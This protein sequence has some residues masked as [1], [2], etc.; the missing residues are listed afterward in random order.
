MLKNLKYVVAI[1]LMVFGYTNAE[2]GLFSSCNA[3]KGKKG[4]AAAHECVEKADPKGDPN[5]FAAFTSFHC[6]K[7]KISPGDK[8]FC[9]V[10]RNKLNNAAEIIHENESASNKRRADSE[11]R[12]IQKDRDNARER[13]RRAQAGE[14]DGFLSK[15]KRKLPW[16]RPVDRV[17]SRSGSKFP[18][19]SERSSRPEPV[20]EEE[21]GEG[22]D[23]EDA[24]GEGDD[25]G[26]DGDGE[27]EDE[28]DE[29]EEPARKPFRR[30]MPKRT[31]RSY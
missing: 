20:E 4:G 13:N 2:A 19:S 7:G 28:E 16:S 18:F 25:E 5:F 14:D 30:V 9:N 26:G 24:V 17:V 29:E 15:V 8:Y 1:G 10:A 6:Q 3:Q 31:Y 11:A 22:D 21:D 27:W 23:D 12:R